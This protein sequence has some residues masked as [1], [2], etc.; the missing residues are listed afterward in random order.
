MAQ[1][2]RKVKEYAPILTGRV[3]PNNIELE[4]SILGAMMLEPDTYILHG[5]S[6]TEDCF[7][8]PENQIIFRAIQSL[9]KRGLPIDLLNVYTEVKADVNNNLLIE[10]AF[11]CTR[12]T[13]SIVG[14]AHAESWAKRL[15]ELKIARELL[16]L[17]YQIIGK[18]NDN[19]DVFEIYDE[20]QNRLSEIISSNI[21][22]KQNDFGTVVRE[23]IKEA[24]TAKS[25]S[26]IVGIRTGNS[27]IDKNML[28]LVAPDVT[29]IAARPGMGKTSFAL[30]LIK[31]IAEQGIPVG[32]FSFEMKAR[33]LVNKIFSR[34][35][36]A[37]VNRI[38]SG[39]LD[40]DEWKRLWSGASELSKLPI[41]IDDN[42]GL[43]IEKIK[44][45]VKTW[46]IKFGIK[47]VFLDYL[48]LVKPSSEMKGGTR[49]NIISHVARVIKQIS[50]EENIPFVALSQLN[51]SGTKEPPELHLLRESG[52][53][54]Q[55]GD[56][57]LFLHQNF[58]KTMD[59][60]PGW[61]DGD[62]EWIVDLLLKK[63]R[64]GSK[65]SREIIFNAAHNEF[66][67]I[68]QNIEN[69]SGLCNNVIF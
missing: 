1:L 12:L 24:E 66:R 62:S 57:V 21:D 65:G 52:E 25:N 43:T 16:T 51:R 9:A 34:Y 54:E 17:S 23:A 30:N 64:L 36:K 56:N 40:N 8:K 69:A 53:I 37:E 49:E 41:H 59:K 33:Q 44:A 55:S 7:Y 11:Y 38:R 48:Q 68:Y 5:E 2:K 27:F 22:S 58:E 3:P 32:V 35:L 6:L 60:Y 47:A 28:G 20:T 31:Q 39:N 26:G 63:C 13:N 15:I 45:I 10:P 50:M 42:G 46:K 18:V 4:N 14:T 29:I 61:Q 19:N 67:N